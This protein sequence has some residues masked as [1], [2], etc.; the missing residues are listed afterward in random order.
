MIV[1]INFIVVQ[2]NMNILFV[3]KE[4]AGADL[5]YRLKKEGHDVRLF[6]EDTNQKHNLENMV[7]KVDNWEEQLDWV[8]KDG[9][10]I[11]DC[12]GHGKTQNELRKRGYCVVGGSELGDKLENDRQY[13]HKIFSVCGI[14]IVPTV[15]FSSA[16]SASNFVKKN[17]GMWVVKQNGHADKGFNYIG[18]MEDGSDVVE[19]LNNYDENNH[20][21]CSSIDL[22]KRILGIEIGVGRYFNGNDWVG[23]IEINIEHKSLCNGGIGPKTHEMG[24]LMWYTDD[25]KNKLFQKT[26][27][28]MKTY[29]QRIN[30]RGDFEINCIVNGD[31]LFPLEATARFGCPSTQLQSELHVS[32][33]GEFLK[34]VADG[35][36]YNLKYKKGFGVIVLVA[37]PTFPYIET[38]KKQQI[39][40]M[41]ILFKN[42]NRREDLEHIHFEE[43][44]RRKEGGEY[45]VSSSTGYVLHVGAVEKTVQK[46]REKAQDVID[47]IVIPKMFYRT[48]IGLSFIEKDRKLL[49]KWGWI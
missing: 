44:S 20:D 6:V 11:F 25:E 42:K 19:L 36:E 30:F 32:P 34:A 1:I 29:L 18:Q 3:S 7:E 26:I 33:W 2:T 38:S 8:G 24:T 28:K 14:D 15:H 47:N 40:G 35:K 17:G 5:S 41:N 46:A 23:P 39:S 4:L 13:G 12:I 45:Y 9:L 43:V 16:K 31:K 27:A 22:Q 21:E 48:D 49:K 10:I 37:V